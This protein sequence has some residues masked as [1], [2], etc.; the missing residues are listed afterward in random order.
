MFPP[1]VFDTIKARARVSGMAI[2]F[3]LHFHSYI[4][5]KVHSICSLLEL[6]TIYALLM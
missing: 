6:G 4:S 5:S 1:H 3:T 2:E